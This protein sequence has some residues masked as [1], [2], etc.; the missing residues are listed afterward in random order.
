M[1]SQRGPIGLHQSIKPTNKI[2]IYVPNT[3]A[4]GCTASGSEIINFGTKYGRTIKFKN[5]F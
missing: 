2:F 3:K 5:Y 1:T 4:K